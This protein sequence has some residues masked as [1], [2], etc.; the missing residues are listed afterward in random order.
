MG[1]RNAFRQN[2]IV[3]IFMAL[4]W[5]YITSYQTYTYSP[6]HVTRPLS[7]A[8]RNYAEPLTVNLLISFDTDYKL[9]LA[10]IEEALH[11]IV[12]DFREFFDIEMNIQYAKVTRICCTKCEQEIDKHRLAMSMPSVTWGRQEMN[13]AAIIKADECGKLTEDYLQ[14][15]KPG[16]LEKVYEWVAWKLRKYYG[17]KETNETLLNGISESERSSLKPTILTEVKK[18]V[19]YQMNLFNNLMLE[20][21][22]LISEQDFK[23]IQEAQ[24]LYCLLDSFN[25]SQS[26]ELSSKLFQLMSTQSLY[27]EEYFQWD[28]KLGIYAPFF[29]PPIFPLIGALYSYMLSRRAKSKLKTD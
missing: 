24:E 25:I 29:V 22:P 21:Q 6:I 10:E 11:S 4:I 8:G 7:D 26:R 27:R 19:S 28:F 3:M 17:L 18:Y 5:W 1:Q 2:S 9:E 16:E 14:Y 20:N 13:L 12:Y 15:I 23:R